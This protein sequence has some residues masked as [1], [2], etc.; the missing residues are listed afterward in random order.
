MII[1]N[2][3]ETCIKM[4]LNIEAT[5]NTTFFLSFLVTTSYHISLQPWILLKW[6]LIFIS[7]KKL[8]F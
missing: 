3:V 7:L 6:I 8:F 4:S 1:L 5:L 2:G